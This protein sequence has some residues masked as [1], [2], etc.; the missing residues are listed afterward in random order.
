MEGIIPC[1]SRYG[2]KGLNGNE[3]QQPFISTSAI[4][5]SLSNTTNHGLFL[6]KATFPDFQAEF[7]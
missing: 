3:I 6:M 5:L 1:S 7:W 4:A 2:K